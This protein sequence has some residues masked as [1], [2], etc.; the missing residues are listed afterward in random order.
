MLKF[1][2]LLGL[3]FP[4]FA[5]ER[6]ILVGGGDPP[7]AA[8]SSFA[9]WS[10]GTKGRLLIIPWSSDSAPAELLKD[11]R[12]EFTP[13]NLTNAEVAPSSAEM[14]TQSDKFYRQLDAATGL[15]FSG[16]DQNYFMAVVDKFPAIR[17]R[18]AQKMMNGI[19][20]YGTSA[21]T[22]VMAK[23]MFTGNYDVNSSK[24][25]GGELFGIDPKAVIMA[26]GLSL[27]RDILVDQ[28]FFVR[29]RQNRFWSAFETCPESKGLGIDEATAVILEDQRWG[30]VAGRGTVL[31][32][33]R[34]INGYPDQVFHLKPGERIDLTYFR[35]IH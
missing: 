13:F 10:G 18:I 21:G 7:A 16:G 23:T 2:I 26:P 32:V 6:L 31:A 30:T 20:V 19:P 15:Y 17:A 11:I 27:L 35:K 33:K 12:D 22:A 3:A 29:K 28:H 1:L 34:G 14:A 8:L 5:R 24:V 9:N 4:A 25:A